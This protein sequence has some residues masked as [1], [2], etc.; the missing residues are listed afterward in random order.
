MSEDIP[1]TKFDIR[2]NLVLMISF[3]VYSTII[4]ILKTAWLFLIIFWVMFALYM[5]LGRYTTCRHCDYLGK[6]CPSWCMG[7][8]G[9]KL[10]TRSE[11]ENFCKEGFLIPFLTDLL[12]L[13]IA[14]A[15]PIIAYL[16]IW[17]FLL[18][19]DWILLILYVGL[20]FVVLGVHSLTG[21]KKCPIEECPLNGKKKK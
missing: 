7:I 19:I 3:L 2:I 5:T 20:L 12:F 14:F 9:A 11:K 15:C 16:L 6:A 21:C 18:V 1:W 13:I 8:I 4:L 17:E 10:Y